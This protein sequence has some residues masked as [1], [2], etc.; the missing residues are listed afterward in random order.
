MRRGRMK[1]PEDRPMGYYHC[2]SRIV[3]GRFIFDAAEKE[4]FCRLMRE[5]EQFC[6]LRV[7]IYCLMSNHFHILHEGPRA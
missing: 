6:E 3:D 1:M 5:Y 7:L 2:I 4:E